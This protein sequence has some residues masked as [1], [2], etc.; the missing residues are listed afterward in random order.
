M[1]ELIPYLLNIMLVGIIISIPFAIRYLIADTKRVELEAREIEEY[2][3]Q[4]DQ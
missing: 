3:N 2:L 4:E 1:F